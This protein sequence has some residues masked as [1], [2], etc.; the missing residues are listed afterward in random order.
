MSRD[1]V[2]CWLDSSFVMHAAAHFGGMRWL[3]GSLFR[4]DDF[5]LRMGILFVDDMVAY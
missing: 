1:V 4:D 2:D 3:T 5:C